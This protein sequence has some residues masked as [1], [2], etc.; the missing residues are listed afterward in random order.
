MKNPCNELKI[1]N[2]YWKTSLNEPTA[3]TPNTHVNPSST[4]NAKAIFKFLQCFSYVALL[5]V[6]R[7]GDF[8]ETHVGL[9]VVIEIMTAENMIVLA[10][11]TIETGRRT[12]M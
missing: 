10:R 9:L 5:S 7:C 1:Q 3:R 4:V 6:R 8:D 12:A 2:R 11:S